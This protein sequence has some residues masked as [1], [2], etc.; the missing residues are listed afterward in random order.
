VPETDDDNTPV[1]EAPKKSTEDL[2]LK[3]AVEV[4]TK[5]KTDTASNPP[6][7]PAAK[8]PGKHPDPPERPLP[9]DLPT[10]PPPPR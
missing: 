1:I 4:V 3:K 10:P 9:P 2:L 7:Q 5:G 8:D 6:I